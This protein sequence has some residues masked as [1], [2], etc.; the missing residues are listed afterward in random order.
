[1]IDRYCLPRMKAIWGVKNKYQKWL[2]I[3]ILACEA[4]AK[5]GKIPEVAVGEIKAKAG[6]DLER[7]DEIERETRHDVIAFLTNVAEHVGPA[8]RFIHYGMTSSDILDTGLALQMVE[9]ANILIADIQKLMDVLKRRAIEHK[10]TVMIGRT[11]GIHAEPITFGFKLVLWI[12]EMKRNLRRLK[13]ARETIRYGKISGTVGTYANV[14]PYV[15]EYVCNKL[16]LRPAQVSTQILQRDRHAEFLTT[17]GIIASSLDKFATEIRNLQRSDILEVEEPF[18]KG[19][20]GSSAMPH[21]RNPIICERISGL[22]RIVRANAFSALENI[23]LWHE[24]DISHSS[25]ERVIIPDST[26]LLDYMLN[27]FTEVMEGLIV[28]PENMRKNL[29]KTG[30]IIFSQRVLLRLVGKGLSR[31]EA[32]RLVQTNAMRVWHVKENFKD[33][34]LKDTEITKYLSPA[35]IE[36]CFDLRYYLRNIDTIFKRLETL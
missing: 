1:M 11:H 21:K 24:R 17:L 23:S 10:D 12:F 22:A 2:E 20:K 36:D 28:Y 25:V 14:D 27:K 3:E 13:S 4:Q 19:Q 30:G 18:A 7:I 33:L 34:L 29:E 6:F 15:E 16:G 5:L 32:Y 31:E 9:A 8:S 35:E 26:L